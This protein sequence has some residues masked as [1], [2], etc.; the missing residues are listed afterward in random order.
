MLRIFVCRSFSRC[1]CRCTLEL[2]LESG[3]CPSHL[4]DLLSALSGS[5]AARGNGADLL[6]DLA[7]GLANLGGLLPVLLFGELA[8]LVLLPVLLPGLAGLLL[9]L[10]P[11]DV[12]ALTKPLDVGLHV[13]GRVAGE[14]RGLFSSVRFSLL[15]VLLHALLPL[16]VLPTGFLFPK[17]GLLLK[18]LFSLELLFFDPFLV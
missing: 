14:S 18:S 7:D 16:L 11:R 1:R 5:L 10:G 6:V 4:S 17:L 3:G 2:V 15:S 8:A 9:S 12:L 13:E